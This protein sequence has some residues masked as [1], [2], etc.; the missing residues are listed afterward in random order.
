LL[1]ESG[2]IVAYVA[3]K[4]NDKNISED[5]IQSVEDKIRVMQSRIGIM[6][7]NDLSQYLSERGELKSSEDFKKA[8]VSEL[9]KGLGEF[10]KYLK[11]ATKSKEFETPEYILDPLSYVRC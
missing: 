2:T 3:K 5:N 4:F 8:G 7:I 11:I 6:N 1:I 10:N 9:F